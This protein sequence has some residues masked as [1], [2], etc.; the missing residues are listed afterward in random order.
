[1]PCCADSFPLINRWAGGRSPC[2]FSA[3]MLHFCLCV[4]NPSL[5]RE[6]R[7]CLKVCLAEC[8]RVRSAAG[9]YSDYISPRPCGE[10]HMGGA[11]LPGASRDRRASC[12]PPDMDD[13]SPPTQLLEVCCAIPFPG[14]QICNRNRDTSWS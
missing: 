12:R 1:M 8:A 11:D 2:R 5:C 13:A 10:E 9:G 4:R 3:A 6:G 14:V 7:E